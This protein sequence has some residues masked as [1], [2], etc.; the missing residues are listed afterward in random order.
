MLWNETRV[1]DER[2]KF[3]AEV[4]SGEERMADLCR[5]FGISRKTGYKWKKRAGNQQAAPKVD[6][7]WHRARKDTAGQAYTEWEAREDA[8]DAEGKS[9]P[10]SPPCS[11]RICSEGRFAAD[12][13]GFI[14]ICSVTTIGA[15]TH[16]QFIS[17]PGEGN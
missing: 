4:L 11:I 6:A 1:A 17:S 7:T 9:T 12:L 10:W 15:L 5:R 2:L 3:I 8:S 14:E 13:I 16:T